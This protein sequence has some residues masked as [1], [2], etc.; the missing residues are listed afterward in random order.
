MNPALIPLISQLGMSLVGAYVQHN[1]AHVSGDIEKATALLPTITAI[2]DALSVANSTLLRAQREGWTPDDARWLPVFAAADAAQA[3][4][5]S[6][7]T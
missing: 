4:A 2:T 3:A 1:N 6:R 5:L 7:L